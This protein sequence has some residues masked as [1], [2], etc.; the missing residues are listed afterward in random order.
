MYDLIVCGGG[1]AGVSAAVAAAREGAYVCLIERENYLGGLSTGGLVNP[2]M[3]HKTRDGKTKLVAGMFDEIKEKLAQ[4]P[5]SIMTNCFDSSSMEKV[6]TEMVSKEDIDLNLNTEITE[7]AWTEP[8]KIFKII[9]THGTFESEK[10]IDAT[11]DGFVSYK[12]GCDYEGG[13]KGNSQALTLMFTMEN[14]DCEKAIKYCI[15]NPDDFLFPKYSKN[16]NPQKIMKSAWSLAGFYKIINAHRDEVSWPGDLIFILSLP[17]EGQVTFNQTHIGVKD[18][19]DKGE[20][21]DAYKEL[22]RQCYA[23]IDFSKKYIPGFENASL[24]KIAPMIGVREGRRIMGEYVFNEMDVAYSRKQKDCICR[25]AYPVDVH[26]SS[27]EGYSKEAGAESVPTPKIDDWYEIPFRSLKTKIPNLLVVGKCLSA[28]QGGQ[29]AA[30]IMPCC[31]AQGQA[32]GVA[33]GLC[34]K[35]NIS[36]N[37]LNTDELLSTLR[38]QGALV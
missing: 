6:L 36:V 17:K 32:A 34:V 10:V 1:L 20:L 3:S 26:K 29:G 2:F 13:D 30:R 9:T 14:V 16:A 5:H 28:T 24:L 7:V 38:A 19:T 27:G 31:I 35:N 33:M 12:Y 23:V 25:L 37:E 21:A 8:N 4:I 15:D 22:E 11:G 18:A